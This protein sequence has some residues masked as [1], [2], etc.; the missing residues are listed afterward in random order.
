MLWLLSSGRRCAVG[1][2]GGWRGAGP[3]RLGIDAH[4]WTS[5]R[6]GLSTLSDDSDADF[7][8]IRKSTLEQLSRQELFQEIQAA[9]NADPVVLFMKGT[10]SAPRCG[11]SRAVAQILM[12]HGVR[13]ASFD[14]L[15]SEALRQGIKEFSDFPTIPQLYVNGELL[16]G[17]DITMKMAEDGSLEKFFT[18]EKVP[19]EEAPP[20]P[21]GDH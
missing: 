17:C 13:F 14:V 3:L 4:Q 20:A 18:E 21:V 10:P 2:V 7:Q 1:A 6:G 8:P 11:F 9:I 16:G 15:Q 19:R 12:Q 5:S